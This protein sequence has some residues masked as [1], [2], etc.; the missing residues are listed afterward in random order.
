MATDAALLSYAG[1]DF[2][3]A[4]SVGGLLDGTGLLRLS[5]RFEGGRVAIPL[6][7]PRIT[8]NLFYLCSGPSSLVVLPQRC[9]NRGQVVAVGMEAAIPLA[10]LT[11]EGLRWYLIL[12]K[13]KCRDTERLL[14]SRA[15]EDYWARHERVVQ[16]EKQG[17]KFRELGPEI[18]R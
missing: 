2:E 3:I 18:S 13:A 15:G 11:V 1:T 6:N 7:D 17:D 16:T 10:D 9:G 12:L 4:M 8:F 5:L 14:V